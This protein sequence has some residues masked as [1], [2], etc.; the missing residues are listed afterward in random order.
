MNT[1]TR[2]QILD[3]AV[4]I[5]HSINTH[6]EGMNHRGSSSIVANVLDCE[7][8]VSNFKLQSHYYIHF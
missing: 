8:I 4:C 5:L 7:I 2:V 3:K 6:G 1:V